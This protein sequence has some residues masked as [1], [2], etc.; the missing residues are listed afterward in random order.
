MLQKVNKLRL[1]NDIHNK[2]FL[3]INRMTI[4]IIFIYLTNGMLILL[5]MFLLFVIYK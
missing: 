3:G 5:C 2:Q 1:N 4:T